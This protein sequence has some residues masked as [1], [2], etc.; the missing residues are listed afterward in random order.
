M[1]LQD[2]LDQSTDT[3]RAARDRVRYALVSLV[4]NVPEEADANGRA[5]IDE[6]SVVR[7]AWRIDA[8]ANELLGLATHVEGVIND[9]RQQQE[10]ADRERD[11]AAPRGMDRPSAALVR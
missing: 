11:E 1:S 9:H 5:E 7:T 8:L 2:Q 4:G 10:Q 3:L 6:P